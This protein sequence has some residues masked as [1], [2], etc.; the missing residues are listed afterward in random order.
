MP[1]RTDIDTRHEAAERNYELPIGTVEC[2]VVSD[3]SYA[4]PDP[5]RAFFAN[6]D[7]DELATV[8]EGYG[9]DPASWETYVSPYPCLVLRTAD[10]TVLVDTGGG[11][12]GEHTG[13]LQSNLRAVGVDPAA[14]DRVL[15]THVHPDHVGG[16]L[17]ADGAPAFPNAQYLVPDREHE[18]WLTDPDL[19]ELQV[20]DHVKEAMI[21]FA[22]TN[23]RPLG[24]AG[25]LDRLPDGPT[26]IVPGVRTLPAPGH[27][28]GHVAV[29]V[30]S[31]GETFLYLVDLVIFPAQIERPDWYA[32]FDLDP[33]TLVDSRRTLLERAV[34]EDALVMAQHFPTPGL[35]HV[36]RTDT[37][38]EWEPLSG[39]NE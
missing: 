29:E 32:A 3:G 6:A 38:Y 35:G 15:L 25:R 13:K 18:F 2:T 19:S 23:V 39:T 4:Y 21:T 30:T 10:H 11:D 22:E 20:P 26:E 8:L 9:I 33:T 37:A 16:T 36:E 31:E 12:L 7:E 5:G 24:E 34:A 14:I 28:P 17:D 27:T 1:A